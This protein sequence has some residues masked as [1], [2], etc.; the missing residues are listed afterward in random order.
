[1]I[2]HTSSPHKARFDAAWC[3]NR[4]FSRAK[5]QSVPRFRAS[6]ALRYRGGWDCVH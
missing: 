6:V 3:A 4:Q 1:M 2:M 5:M